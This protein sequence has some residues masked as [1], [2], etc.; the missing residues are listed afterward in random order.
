M[1][2]VVL[3]EDEGLPPF[4]RR[5][6]ED[7]YLDLIQYHGKESPMTVA[8]LT[9]GEGPGG[10]ETAGLEGRGYKALRIRGEEDLDRMGDYYPRPCLLDAFVKGQAGGTG[11]RIDKALVEKARG[12]GELWLAGGLNPDN[13]GVLMKDFRPELIDASSGLEAEPGRKDPDKLRAF[14]KEINSHV[15]IQ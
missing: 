3:E 8:G 13:V 12:L 14:F 4:V 9:D 5:L 10:D 7:G 15:Q 11:K 2:V 1:G 6:L